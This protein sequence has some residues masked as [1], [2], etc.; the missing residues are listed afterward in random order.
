MRQSL[1]AMQQFDVIDHHGNS[2]HDSDDD[3]DDDDELAKPYRRRC[4]DGQSDTDVSN[5]SD[6]S[7]STWHCEDSR[8]FR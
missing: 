5:M 2:N 7:S 4:V 8:H 6:I 1:T 3:D